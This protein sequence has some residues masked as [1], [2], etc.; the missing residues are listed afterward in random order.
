MSEDGQE[1]A[2]VSV[3]DYQ[4]GVNVFDELV[5][6]PKPVADY[7]TQYVDPSRLISTELQLIVLDG[8]G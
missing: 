1:L 7:R 2:R 4:S 6:P 3:I 8:L 5:K